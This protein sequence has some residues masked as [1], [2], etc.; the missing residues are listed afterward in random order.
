MDPNTLYNSISAK[1]VKRFPGYAIYGYK[2]T[3]TAITYGLREVQPREVARKVA[4]RWTIKAESPELIE[5][6]GTKNPERRLE[7]RALTKKGGVVDTL[8]TVFPLM[9]Q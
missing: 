1:I 3:P 9:E 7:L 8:V 4:R 6:Q 5:L 2:F